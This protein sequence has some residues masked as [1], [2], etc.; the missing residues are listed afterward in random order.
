MEL[1]KP[2]IDA[3]QNGVPLPLCGHAL[4]LVSRSH[5]LVC[6]ACGSFWD[7][8]ALDRPAVYD[9]S[10]PEQ[11][12]HFDATIGRHKA[13]TLQQWLKKLGI[14]TT[15]LAVCEVGFGGAFCLSSLANSSRRVFGIEAIPENIE[16]AVELGI[17]RDSLYLTGA[18][19]EVLAERI[20]LWIFQDSFEHLESPGQFLKWMIENSSEKARVLVVAPD[21]G[22]L[23][24]R[25]MGTWWPH[26]VTDHRFHWTR[27]GIVDFFS[28]HDFILDKAFFPAKYVSLTMAFSHLLLKVRGLKRLEPWLRTLPL[29]DCALPFNL[30]EMGLLFSKR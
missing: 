1:K 12:S 4:R 16:H 21:G 28:R 19:P 5:R 14:A 22:S 2:H 15:D 24:E 17:D 9:Y 7:K 27:K 6:T 11:R 10:Y 29:S 26:R 25:I 30:G 18:I 8:R 13:R 20:D 23:S 3:P